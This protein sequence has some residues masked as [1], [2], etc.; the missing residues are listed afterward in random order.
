MDSATRDLIRNLEFE[1]HAICAA[2]PDWD[3]PLFDF[4][5]G[6]K[7]DYDDIAEYVGE[8]LEDREKGK[9]Q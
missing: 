8:H 4:L 6:R 5:M 3:C 1:Y 2:N 9:A 7:I